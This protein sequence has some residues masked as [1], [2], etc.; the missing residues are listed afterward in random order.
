MDDLTI[1]IGLGSVPL[2]TGLTEVVKRL[3]GLSPETQDRVVPFISV[4]IGIGVNYLVSTQLVSSPSIP[5]I[6][7]FGLISGLASSGLWSGTRSVA[8]V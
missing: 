4:L 6:I 3:A 1:Y 8:G 2:T 7:V 5:A